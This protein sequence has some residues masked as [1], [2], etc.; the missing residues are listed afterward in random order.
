MM[1]RLVAGSST[2]RDVSRKARCPPGREQDASDVA[3]L[4]HF[5]VA[6]AELVGVYSH[7]VE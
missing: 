1:A 3:E 6:V 2:A 7:S 4:L 5:A